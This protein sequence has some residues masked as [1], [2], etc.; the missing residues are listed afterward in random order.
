MTCFRVR[1]QGGRVRGLGWACVGIAHAQ[2]Q[3]AQMGPFPCIGVKK[4]L[5][6][7][8]QSAPVSRRDKRFCINVCSVATRPGRGCV[9]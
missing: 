1:V 9:R 6:D 7:F 3:E 4:K 5:V 2:C 8:S